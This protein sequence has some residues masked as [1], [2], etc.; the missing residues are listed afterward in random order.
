[1]KLSWYNYQLSIS[2]ELND[3]ETIEWNFSLRVGVSSKFYFIF[4]DMTIL[5]NIIKLFTK[6][7]LS[8]YIIINYL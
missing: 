2:H 8:P 1:M 7:V 4:Y 5:N 6:I 3:Y